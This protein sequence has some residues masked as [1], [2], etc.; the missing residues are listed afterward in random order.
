[1]TEGAG[2]RGRWTGGGQARVGGQGEGEEGG[3]GWRETEDVTK[4]LQDVSVILG[5]LVLIY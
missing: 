2:A 3:G 4:E 1:M 5:Q